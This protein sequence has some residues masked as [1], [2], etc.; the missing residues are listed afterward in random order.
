M[1]K[2]ILMLAII[3][4]AAAQIAMAQEFGKEK[5]PSCHFFR[6]N[7]EIDRAELEACETREQQM[8]L[9]YSKGETFECHGLTA[10]VGGG[11][12]SAGEGRGYNVEGV[13]GYKFHLWEPH[14]AFGHRDGMT[15]FGHTYSGDYFLAGAKIF[16]ASHESQEAR[17][18]KGRNLI[19]GYAVIQY[20]MVAHHHPLL[21]E[22]KEVQGDFSGYSSL[23]RAGLG[24]RVFLGNKGYINA[25]V[26][27][28]TFAAAS[29]IF[30]ER[31]YG[32][33]ATVALGVKF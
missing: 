24:M 5:T 33:N 13:V 25:E 23:W 9:I 3:M 4:L 10:Q 15:L 12:Y 16:W 14:V 22:A 18:K 29:G 11:I 28:E 32:I 1:K 6:I 2:M 26:T 27:G 7:Q 30:A 21:D 8:A 19:Q 17:Y 31:S 20:G